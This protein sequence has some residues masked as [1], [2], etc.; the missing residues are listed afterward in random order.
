MKYGGKIIGMAEFSSFHDRLDE[1]LLQ[2]DTKTNE[3]QG[4]IGG[5]AWDIQ[6]HYTNMYDTERQNLRG[7]VQVPATIFKYDKFKEQIQANLYEEYKNFKRYAEPRRY[8]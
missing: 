2:I 8:N 4:W 6:I 7:C 3:E 5:S 1:P